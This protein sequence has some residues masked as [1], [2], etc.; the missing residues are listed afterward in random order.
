M[1][2]WYQPSRSLLIRHS[3]SLT[4]PLGKRVTQGVRFEAAVSTDRNRRGTAPSVSALREYGALSAARVS[5]VVAVA[6]ADER[7]RTY[8]RGA[9]NGN[10]AKIGVA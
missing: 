7:V 8:F 2:P 4:Q 6:R 10:A 5:R 1:S 3:L 9:A